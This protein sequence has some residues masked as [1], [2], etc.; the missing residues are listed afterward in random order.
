[1][2]KIDQ[3]VVCKTYGWKIG[4]IQQVFDDG[5]LV[6]S[7]DGEQISVLEKDIL[8]LKTGFG[9]KL[10]QNKKFF[11]INVFKRLFIENSF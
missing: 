11:N 7:I 1:M 10:S 2:Y 6:I 9:C 8:V 3:I 5:S 4:L